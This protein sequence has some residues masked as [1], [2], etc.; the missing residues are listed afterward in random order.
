M[1]GGGLYPNFYLR[2]WRNAGRLK[3][4]VTPP[5]QKFNSFVE[6][7]FDPVI[8]SQLGISDTAMIRTQISSL[9][10]TADLPKVT[11]KTETK[12]QYNMKRVVQ[13]GVEFSPINIT[14]IDTVNNEWLTIFMRYFSYLYMQAR[15]KT[16]S[17]N[18]TSRDLNPKA[19]PSAAGTLTATSKFMADGGVFDSNAAGF[20]LTSNPNF[21]SQIKIVNY[22][23]GKGVEYIMFR[24]V[25]TD[26]NPGELDYSSS[27]IR[28]FSFGFEYE[29]FVINQKVNF[30]L[31]EVDRAR[32]EDAGVNFTFSNLDSA[33]KNGIGYSQKD[34]QFLGGSNAELGRTNQ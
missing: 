3:P 26:F 10:Q 27:D 9:V 7:V 20:N 23:G 33:T 15:N 28:T 16:T 19:Y 22:A 6:F 13:T 24:P 32:F 29:N 34:L 30:Q 31:N 17:G 5:R 12:N 18:G 21:I 1:P 4:N 2:D 14:V 8:V 11:F 25:I